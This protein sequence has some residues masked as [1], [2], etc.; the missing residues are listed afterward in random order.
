MRAGHVPLSSSYISF[1]HSTV[2]KCCNTLKSYFLMSVIY[3]VVR[4]FYFPDLHVVP[5]AGKKARTNARTDFD[6]SIRSIMFY[7][8]IFAFCAQKNSFVGREAGWKTLFYFLL[9]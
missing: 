9:V 5:L 1:G 2:C 8:C 4:W 7:L 6:C 3:P